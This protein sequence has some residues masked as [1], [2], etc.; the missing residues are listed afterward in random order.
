[1]K[2]LVKA[3]IFSAGILASQLSF[4]QIAVVVGAKSDVAAL[5]VD[6]VAALFLGK[7]EKFPSGAVASLLDQPSGSAIRTAFYDKVTGKSEPQVKSGWSRLV[8]SGKGTPPKEVGSSAE[9]KKQ[10][11]SNPNTIGYIEKSTVDSTVK[12]LLSVE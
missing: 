5:T 6:Q 1:M 10:V 8:F 7:T 2:N 4:A 12:V 11:A 9:V 3:L